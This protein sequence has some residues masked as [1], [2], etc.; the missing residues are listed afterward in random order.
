MSRQM[1]GKIVGVD[2][3]KTKDCKKGFG[4]FVY[5][6]DN[7]CKEQERVTRASKR[8]EGRVHGQ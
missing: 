6:F 7:Q 1:K 3:D 5:R 8:E 2:I 4:N